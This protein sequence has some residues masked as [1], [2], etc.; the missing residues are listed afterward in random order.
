MA[1]RTE[2]PDHESR[3]ARRR[4]RRR[5]RASVRLPFPIV[6]LFVFVASAVAPTAGATVILD[7]SGSRLQSFADAATGSDLQELFPATLPFIDS[8]TAVETTATSHTIYDFSSTEFEVIIAHETSVSAS[9]ARSDGS[10]FFTVDSDVD[11]ELSGAYSMSGS[12]CLVALSGR[13]L[14]RTD[15]MELYLGSFLNGSC[16][17]QDASLFYGG[18]PFPTGSELGSLTGT[19]TAGHDYFFNYTAR[20]R[21]GGDGVSTGTGLIRLRF[22]GEPPVSAPSIG[23]LGLGLLGS[24]LGLAGWRSL[25]TRDAGRGSASTSG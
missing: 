11:Y 8:H 14:D 24:L 5:R 4:P 19:L 7:P 23:A 15:N 3:L 17:V 21:G 1:M 6:C 13:L 12:T 18:G 16:G 9:T 25:R 10:V 22:L 2:I 20:H